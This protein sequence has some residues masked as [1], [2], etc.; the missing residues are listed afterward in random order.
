[1]IFTCAKMTKRTKSIY[2][3]YVKLPIFNEECFVSFKYLHFFLNFHPICQS[4]WFFQR[5]FL[6]ENKFFAPN[7]LLLVRTSGLCVAMPFASL[8]PLRHVAKLRNGN[9][10]W[11]CSEGDWLMSSYLFSEMSRVSE[12][13]GWPK[14]YIELSENW[15]SL[16][17]FLSSSQRS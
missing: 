3:H 16:L 5:T 2:I 13:K 4:N 11:S 7:E 10:P 9:G 17:V 1:M 15:T 14:R 6:C 12:G 8:L